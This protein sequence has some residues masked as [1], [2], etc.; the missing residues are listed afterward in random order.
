MTRVAV[1]LDRLAA[2]IERAAVF[3]S[4]LERLGAEVEARVA[5]VHAEWHGAAA[6]AHA[7][8]HAQWRVGAGEVD[9]ALAMLRSIASGA[10]ANYAAA[11][12]AN[13]RMWSR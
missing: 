2:L 12:A 1:D 10:H 13:R 7:A 6:S 8:A 9:A 3:Q 11:A 4:R 5:A